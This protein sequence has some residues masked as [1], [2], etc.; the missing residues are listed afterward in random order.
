[1]DHPQGQGKLEHRDCSVEFYILTPVDLDEHPYLLFTS[2]G[3]HEH[4]PPPPSKTPVE[5]MD[6]VIKLIQD[7]NEPSMT[8]RKHLCMPI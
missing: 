1:M 3:K 4:P 7:M 6:Q 5:I 2:V 8:L